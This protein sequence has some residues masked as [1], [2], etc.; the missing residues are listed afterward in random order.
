ME[1]YAKFIDYRAEIV[2]RREVMHAL[3]DFESGET[4]IF[5]SAGDLVAR[6]S[7]ELTPALD[8]LQGQ[9]DEIVSKL[10]KD[11]EEP[12]CQIELEAGR[13][14]LSIPRAGEAGRM[15]EQLLDRCRR[16]KSVIGE[17][18]KI[19]RTI[20]R[21]PYSQ[22]LLDF[23]TTGFRL[24]TLHSVASFKGGKLQALH[25]LKISGLFGHRQKID[26]KVP[27]L[28]KLP[29]ARKLT[30]RQSSTQRDL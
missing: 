11:R 13:A 14:S 15:I 23:K 24:V 20:E 28:L 9:R 18:D 25:P 3:M 2:T 1:Y 10:Q 7:A 4:T 27:S 26:I 21:Q 5:G 16:L 6:S 12:R 19:G 30:T 8:L 22:Y 17:A 29:L